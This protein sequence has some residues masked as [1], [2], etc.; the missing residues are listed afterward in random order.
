MERMINM[1][2][3]KYL[4][5]LM[6]SLPIFWFIL[7]RHFSLSYI[8]PK[9]RT[10]IAMSSL[11]T[12][13]ERY[14]EE[15]GF[16]PTREE[17]LLMLIRLKYL[18]KIPRDGWRREIIYVPDGQSFQLISLGPDGKDGGD[19]DDEDIFYSSCKEKNRW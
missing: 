19:H 6:M 17:G 5:L 8:E 13:L 9:K 15:K 2:A 7:P 1:K 16:F 18:K 14:K 11:A 12:S 10:C 4:I 3:L